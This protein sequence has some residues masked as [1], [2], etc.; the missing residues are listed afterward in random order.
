MQV[1]YNHRIFTISDGMMKCDEMLIKLL[2]DYYMAAL[3]IQH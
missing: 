1:I 2:F 3:M